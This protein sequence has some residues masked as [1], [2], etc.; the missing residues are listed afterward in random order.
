MTPLCLL[1]IAVSIVSTSISEF[2]SWLLVYRK[3]AW[4][5]LKQNGE[6]LYEQYELISSMKLQHTAAK[7]K[8]DSYREQI[9]ANN[10]R[11][12]RLRMVPSLIT[13]VTI[14]SAMF[15]VRR[16]FK[17]RVVAILPFTA[18][19]FIARIT[20]RGLE[21]DDM[22]QMSMMGLYT[23]SSMATRAIIQRACGHVPPRSPPI[24]EPPAPAEE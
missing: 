2:I 10:G 7:G 14:F 4:K 8:L 13:A 19:G 11:M 16:W 17:G 3:P 21:G 1:V 22:T 6:R 18:V 15:F 5:E 12:S 23:L 24:M 20:H 9:K